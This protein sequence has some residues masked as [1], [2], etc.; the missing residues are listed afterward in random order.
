MSLSVV[1]K[2]PP[3]AAGSDDD[4]DYENLTCEHCDESAF[5][6]W[7]CMGVPVLVCSNC[8]KPQ[9]AVTWGRFEE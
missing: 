2:T 8:G 3:E 6:G 1:A 5:Y 9:E 7:H 4:G